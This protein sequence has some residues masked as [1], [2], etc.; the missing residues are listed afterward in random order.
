MTFPQILLA[1]VYIAFIVTN[2]KVFADGKSSS[3]FWITLLTAALSVFLLCGSNVADLELSDT[4]LD[5]SGYRFI[6]EDY[7]IKSHAEYSMYYLFYG[8][9][10][11]GQKLGLSYRVWWTIMSIFAMSVIFISCRIHGFNFNFFLATFM[12]YYELVFYSGLKFFYGFCFLLLAYGFLL[13]NTPK[14]YFLFALF[15][16]IAAGFHMMYY[17]FL[18]LL[19][20]PIKKP[21]AIVIPVVIATVLLTFIMRVSGSASSIMAPFFNALDNDHISLYTEVTVR[22]GFYLAIAIQLIVVFI[23]F[24]TRK[25][26][27]Y[28]AQAS[29][30]ADSLYYT[31]LLSLLFCPFY[32]VALTFMRLITAFSLVVVASSSSILNDSRPSRVLCN[33]LSLLVVF[34][35][36]FIRFLTSIGTSRGFFEASV[37]PFFDVL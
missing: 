3:A 17:L 29:S 13:R 37:L 16:C 11:L 10:A 36:L 1:C 18:I 12:A 21:K 22:L 4:G 14:G 8:S 19:I 35:F 6:Y 34:S 30:K 24:T 26:E 25:Y 2:Y 33:K 5:I 9:M 27:K 15:T 28:N 20:K 7:D 23:A 31:V 32:A